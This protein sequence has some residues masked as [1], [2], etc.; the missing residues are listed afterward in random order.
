MKARAFATTLVVAALATAQAGPVRAD[1]GDAIAGAIVGGLIGNA[2]AKDQQKRKAAATPS[3]PKSSKPAVSTAQREANREVQT[4]LNHFGYNVGTPD[5]AI[6][7]K[8]RSAIAAYQAT[9][10]YPP[11]GQLTDYERSILVT[12]YHRAIAGGPAVAQVAAAHPMGMKGLLLVQRDEMAG[13]P[14]Q[15]G[16]LAVTSAGAAVG[17]AA[18]AAAGAVVQPAPAPALPALVAEPAPMPAAPAAPQLPSFGAATMVSLSSHC[19]QVA[20]QTNQN[21]GYATLATLADPAQA[22]SEQF[23]LARAVAIQQGEQLVAKVPGLLPQQVADQCRAFGPVLK[24]H[25]NAVSLQPADAVLAGVSAFAAGSGQSPAQLS[26]T[27]KIC[28]GAGYAMD[29]M[30]VALGSAL[31]LTALGETGYAELAGHHLAEGIGATRR[32]DLAQGWYEMA[33]AAPVPVVSGMAP[34]RG[35]MIRKAVFLLNGRSEAPAPAA[36]ALPVLALTP[37]VVVSAPPP[38]IAPAPVTEAAAQPLPEAGQA[39]PLTAAKAVSFATALP[40]LM[41]GN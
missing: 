33:L 19:N 21:G 18:G 23:C 32:P 40:R 4:A 6:G 7:P 25:V 10:G 13:L 20:L 16:N 31:V 1:M 15:A 9:L 35:E 38:V 11:S 34:D 8:S 39:P 30:D 37:E 22:L 12:A 27:A 29:D 3:K 36:P 5:G 14:S 28:L 17:L 41:L 26:G 2:I 24:D